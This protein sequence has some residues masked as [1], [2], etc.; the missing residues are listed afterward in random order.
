MS[1]AGSYICGEET[2]LLASLEGQR[3]EVQVR[4]PFPTQSGL[5]GKPTLLSNVETFALLPAILTDGGEAF[6]KIGTESST[7]PKLV[8]LDSRFNKPGLYEIEMGTPLSTVI[9]EF[10]D[11]FREPVKAVQI[12]GPL[13]GLVPATHFSQLNLDFE[14]FDQAGFLLGHA[15]F[16]SIPEHVPIIEYMEHLFE[17]TKDES[18]GKCFPCRYGSVRGFEMLNRARKGEDKA[19]LHL[20]E[21]LLETLEETSLCALGGGLPLPIRNALEHFADELQV[22]FEKDCTHV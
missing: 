15:S 12:G 8:S 9:D 7:G 11:G 3:P 21:D 1:G 20:L 17:F 2:A 6:A 4:P 22:Y 19:D 18:C 13:G 14:S 5:F 10:G 16:V